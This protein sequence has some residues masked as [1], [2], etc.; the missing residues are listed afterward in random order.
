VFVS[1]NKGKTWTVLPEVP[2]GRVLM[3][4]ATEHGTLAA[5]VSGVFR[6]TVGRQSWIKAATPS[7]ARVQELFTGSGDFAALVSTNGLF[8][9]N[10]AGRTWSS[11][12]ALPHSGG[13]NSIAGIGG[14]SGFMLAGS[15]QGLMRS[16]DGCRS[17]TPVREGLSSDTVSLVDVEGAQPALAFAVQ[18]GRVFV[19]ADRGRSWKSLSDEG[20]LGVFPLTLRYLARAD[21]PRLFA[22]FPGSGVMVHDVEGETLTGSRLYH[23]PIHRGV[24]GQ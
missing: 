18:Y 8:I 24:S 15:S 1:T 16:D 4:K 23:D 10:D 6:W 22:L 5:G 2:G 14:E 12:E 7:P 21:G 17:W 9:S 13:L 11:C 19:S 20:R 3:V